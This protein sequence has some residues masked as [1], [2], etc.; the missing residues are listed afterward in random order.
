[1]EVRIHKK[2]HLLFPKPRAKGFASNSEWSEETAIHLADR[3]L[4]AVAS[5]NGNVSK[6]KDVDIEHTDGGLIKWD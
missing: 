4:L 2:I 3:L 6:S 5:G 1:M